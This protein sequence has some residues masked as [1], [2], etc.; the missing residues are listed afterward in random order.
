MQ[1]LHSQIVFAIYVG[2]ALLATG[3]LTLDL[4]A[5]EAKV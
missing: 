5:A 3:L 4:V 1:K 2:F